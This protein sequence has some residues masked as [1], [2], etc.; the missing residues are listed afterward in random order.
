M[1]DPPPAGDGAERLAR[2]VNVI[3]G[4]MPGSPR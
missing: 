3:D 4:L 2:L 1:D